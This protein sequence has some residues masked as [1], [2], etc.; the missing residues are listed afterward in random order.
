MSTWIAL[1]RGIGGGIRSVPMKRLREILEELGLADVRTYL[2]TGNVVFERPRATAAKLSAAIAERVSRE[3]DFDAKV[4]VLSAA[5]LEA[6]ADANPFR[7]AEREPRSLHLFFLAAKPRSPD[8]AAMKKLQ[9]ASERFALRDRV[10]YFHTPDGFGK[11]KLATRVERLLGV[12][13][14]A[15][16]WR[17]VCKVRELAAVRS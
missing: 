9:A 10:L 7:E 17:T 3:F 2:A 11:S 15:R 13:A 1:V 8:L 6:A 5:E 16:N 12:D 4:L 14:T